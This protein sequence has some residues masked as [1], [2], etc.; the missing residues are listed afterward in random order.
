M[1]LSELQ[2]LLLILTIAVLA[3]LLCEWVPW[4]RLPL[5]VMEI[6]LGILIG[7]QVLDWASAGPSMP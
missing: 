3:P 7:P 1:T 5:V 6:S 2:S 4:L